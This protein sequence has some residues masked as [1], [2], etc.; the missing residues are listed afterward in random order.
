MRRRLLFAL[1]LA[2]LIWRADR[3]SHAWVRSDTATVLA[4]AE[5]VADAV[6]DRAGD[7]GIGTGS[8]RFDGEWDLVTC[9]MAV[10]G[11]SQ[12][13][14]AQPETEETSRDARDAC[15]AWLLTP[16]AQRF[17]REAWGG[18]PGEDP[19]THAYLGYVGLALGVDC[20]ARGH[21]ASPTAH[22]A[23]VARL[24][25]GLEAPIHRFQTY[26][27]E[28][29]PADLATVAAAIAT[30]ARCH[31]EPPPAALSAWVD[32][33]EAAAVEP[34]TGWVVQAL[35]P[36]N[37][38]P[39]DHPRGSGTAFTAAWMAWVDPAL[40]RRLSRA[41]GEL[42]ERTVLGFSAMREYPPGTT[43]WGDI[44]SGPV[45]LGVGVSAT[46]FAL[47]SARTHGEKARLRRLSRTAMLFG[48]PTPGGRHFLTGGRIGDAILLAMLTSPRQGA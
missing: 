26:P 31:G 22:D 12:V 8:A 13:A 32:R 2:A 47:A 9:Q 10:I 42:G 4:L 29:Y 17:G 41:H 6:R 19:A 5:G 28:V 40:S 35:H 20:L 27:G 36:R 1:A 18:P 44:D 24:T 33:F 7:A 3:L 39:I 48:L 14:L 46:G 11:L 25:A 38:D 15:L 21:S 16:E 45:V 30:H 34:E 23:L 37:G 43:G